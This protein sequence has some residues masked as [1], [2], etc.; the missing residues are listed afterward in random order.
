MLVLKENV[1]QVT[2][3]LHTTSKHA[4]RTYHTQNSLAGWQ[5]CSCFSVTQD[6]H[7]WPP[8]RTAAPSPLTTGAATSAGS[9]RGSCHCSCGCRET[10]PTRVL[11][12][13]SCTEGRLGGSQPFHVKH[14]LPA[15]PPAQVEGRERTQGCPPGTKDVTDMTHVNSISSPH[16][17]T[18]SC[19]AVTLCS[20]L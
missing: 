20:T 19:A 18:P 11:C 6:G 16:R 10:K 8:Q 17:E 9:H 2:P 15:P 1:S 3:T 13:E 12:C 5:K 14:I 7:R 4:G